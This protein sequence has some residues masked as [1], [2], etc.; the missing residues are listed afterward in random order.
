MGFLGEIV[1]AL[2]G[3]WPNILGQ[4]LRV[5][6]RLDHFRNFRFR[7]FRHMHDEWFV[8][9]E[10][11]FHRRFAAVDVD[12]FP[13]LSGRVEQAANYPPA[14]IAVLEFD[15]RGFDRK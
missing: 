1:N 12:A 4:T 9:D 13:I 7:A 8:L 5:I 2:G 3:K 10:G 14:D 11:P 6:W 15:M